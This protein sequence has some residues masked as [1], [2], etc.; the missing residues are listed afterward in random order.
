[1]SQT[2]VEPLTLNIKGKIYH[3][4]EQALVM[5]IVNVTPDSFYA[6]SRTEVS[7]Q[8]LAARVEQMREEGVDIVD[9]GGCSTRPGAPELSVEEEWKR[10]EMPLRFLEREYPSLPV[11]LDTFRSEIAQRAVEEFGVGIINDV[12]GGT[13]DDKMFSTMASLQVPYVLMHMRG[14]PATM[15]Q[16]T[17]YEDVTLDV[18]RDLE[19]KKN[20]LRAAGFSA[21]IIMDPGFGFSKNQ[22]QNYSM[23]QRLNE[24]SLLSAPLLVGI[25]RKRMIWG[26]LH[27]TA[28]EALNGTTVLNTIALLNGAHIL[29]VH[30][31]KA[32]VEAVKLV[33]A[34]R[35]SKEEKETC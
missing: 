35:N 22:E 1:M 34:V 28:E 32:C 23:L 25:S 7:E 5:G 14:T 17:D 33:Q 9:L 26:V 19:R 13:L 4:H 10:L 29:R 20:R 8:A 6:G 3:L 30:D 18:I 27:N 31:V 21:D 15:S 12:S 11:S 2:T 24:F 16:L